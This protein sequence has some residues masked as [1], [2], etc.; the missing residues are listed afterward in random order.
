MYAPDDHGAIAK[1]PSQNILNVD[2][3]KL[4]TD[5]M[6]EEFEKGNAEK[7]EEFKRQMMEKLGVI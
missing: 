6:Q 7:K 3:M 4:F 1:M 2:D 5:V